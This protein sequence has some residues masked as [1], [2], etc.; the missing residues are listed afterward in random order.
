MP[1]NHTYVVLAYPWNGGL[2]LWN[3]MEVSLVGGQTVAAL[4]LVDVT[5]QCQSKQEVTS[6]ANVTM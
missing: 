6:S 4:A 3:K 5:R 2:A 1:P